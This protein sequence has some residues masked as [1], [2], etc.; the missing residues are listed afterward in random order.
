[1][2]GSQPGEGMALVGSERGGSHL[3]LTAKKGLFMAE[4][5]D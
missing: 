1:M 5:R 2:Q 4:L 3:I